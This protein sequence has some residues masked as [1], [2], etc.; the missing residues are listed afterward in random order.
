MKTTAL[1][2]MAAVL[3]ACSHTPKKPSGQAF[4]INTTYQTGR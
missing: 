3:A 1:I 2:L 4:P